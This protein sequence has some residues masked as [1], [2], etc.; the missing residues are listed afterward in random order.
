MTDA[1]LRLQ[2][3]GRVEWRVG[4]AVGQGDVAAASRALAGHTAHVLVPGEQVLLTRVTLP[5]Q[6]PGDI[7]RALPYALE[8]GLVEALERQHMAW[9]G[10]AGALAA[11]VVERSRMDAWVQ[12]LSAIG[13]DVAGLLPD[14]LALPWEPGTWS[15]CLIGSRALVRHGPA[16]GIACARSNL[17]AVLAALSAE[18]ADAFDAERLRVWCFDG[19]LPAVLAGAG[20]PPLAA[21]FLQLLELPAR[22]PDLLRGEYR[23]RLPRRGRR[24][25]RWRWLAAAAVSCLLSLVA[26]QGVR[27]VH[28]ATERDR[29]RAAIR[30][31]FHAALPE[32]HRVVD[33]RVQLQQALTGLQSGRAEDGPLRLLARAAPALAGADRIHLRRIA[34]RDGVLDAAVQATDAAALNQLQLRLRADGLEVSFIP[35]DRAATPTRGRLRIRGGR[36]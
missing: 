30:S 27:Y 16:D 13:V 29:L 9:V 5:S 36:S 20:E 15:V 10:G 12:A 32:V 7:E 11:A 24:Q 33:A 8:D 6:R 28:A 23:R 34:W 2:D 22:A 35:D 14:V 1:L 26:L 19:E 31:E 25:P 3:D 4:D 17:E 21:S 18:L